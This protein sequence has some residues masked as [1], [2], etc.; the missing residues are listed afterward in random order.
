MGKN[1]GYKSTLMDLGIHVMLESRVTGVEM[2]GRRV[3][4]L[5]LVTEA[6]YQPT[7][8]WITGTAGTAGNCAR[9]N[10]SCVMC[11]LRA[12]LLPRVSIASKAEQGRSPEAF[13]AMSGR[14]SW[15]RNLLWLVR[16]EEKGASRSGAALHSAPR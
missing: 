8:L 12:P 13:R 14:A 15:R 2:D 6:A 7:H 5:A 1:R 3:T 16:T 9:I 11:V 10:G 4:H